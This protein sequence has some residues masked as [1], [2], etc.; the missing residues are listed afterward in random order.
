MHHLYHVLSDLPPLGKDYF[1]EFSN[2]RT[3]V[4]LSWR[5]AVLLPPPTLYF[6]FWLFVRSE[7]QLETD[8]NN[9]NVLKNISYP[10]G[11]MSV[12]AYKILTVSG[13]RHKPPNHATQRNLSPPHLFSFFDH[14][15]K[16]VYLMFLWW[17]YSLLN[18]YYMVFLV[19]VFWKMECIIESH[20][21]VKMFVLFWLI[22]CS[23]IPWK[24]RENW[25]K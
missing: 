23:G 2:D 1:S 7:F 25:F 12:S 20:F 22:H 16:L 18:Y 5:L 10:F 6:F 3:P 21:W 15:V 17:M 9:N 8:R 14:N 19:L 4:A 11:I 13:N 24:L